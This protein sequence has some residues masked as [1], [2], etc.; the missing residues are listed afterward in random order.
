MKPKILEVFVWDM[1]RQ[2]ACVLLNDGNNAWTGDMEI[3]DLWNLCGT[4][5]ETR[6]QFV[7]DIHGQAAYLIDMGEA[8]RTSVIV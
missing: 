4:S 5:D 1:D 7:S 8:R 3:D 2:R 6:N